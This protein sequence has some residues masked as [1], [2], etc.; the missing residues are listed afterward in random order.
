MGELNESEIRM[1]RSK[2]DGVTLARHQGGKHSVEVATDL[3][4]AVE[5]LSNANVNVNVHHD[6]SF[7]PEL[8][9]LAREAGVPN[10]KIRL[11]VQIVTLLLGVFTAPTPGAAAL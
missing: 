7:L 10:P 3:P 4:S 11:A 2:L 6:F 8:A 5:S 9:A 1:L